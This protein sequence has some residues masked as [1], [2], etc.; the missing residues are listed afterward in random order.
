MTYEEVILIAFLLL[1]IFASFIISTANFDFGGKMSIYK[2]LYPYL[3]ITLLIIA[4][5]GSFMSS[6]AI[7]NLSKAEHAAEE[8]SYILSAEKALSE[9]LGSSDAE[10]FKGSDGSYEYYHD[11]VL[12]SVTI[13]GKDNETILIS[14][15]SDGKAIYKDNLK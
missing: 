11:E 12:Y 8:Q 13:G 9:M 4:L 15:E 3:M 14:K 2:H 5:T 1:G 7:L 6:R 10:Y